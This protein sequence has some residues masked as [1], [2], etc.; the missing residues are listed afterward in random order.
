M[1]ADQDCKD[2]D[3][4]R[5]SKFAF[6]LF[7]NTGS[8]YLNVSEWHIVTLL[9]MSKKLEEVVY[10]V[11]VRPWYSCSRLKTFLQPWAWISGPNKKLAFSV[12]V[13]LFSLVVAFYVKDFNSSF[14][15]IKHYIY[16]HCIFSLLF[17]T[18]VDG[19]SWMTRQTSLR[20]TNLKRFTCD[21]RIY[22]F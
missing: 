22:A 2:T 17:L 14:S 1:L 3:K 9:R 10:C 4:E 5:N 15:W 19:N 13:I 16:I 18:I 20:S 21:V 12:N 11:I 6:I 7:S 8:P